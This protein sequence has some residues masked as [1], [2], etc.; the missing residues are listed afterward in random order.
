MKYTRAGNDFLYLGQHLFVYADDIFSNIMENL[1]RC[2]EKIDRLTLLP[3]IK[4]YIYYSKIFLRITRVIE[5][6]YLIRGNHPNIQQ[7]IQMIS[8]YLM[9]WN[10]SD[11]FM[12]NHLKYLGQKGGAKIAKSP[13]LRKYMLELNI[14]ESISDEKALEYE[15]IFGQSTPEYESV[16]ENL[17]Y[18]MKN[19]RE[20]FYSEF[21]SSI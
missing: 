14:P 3:E 13:N 7:I 16:D 18:L 2:L 6:H 15:D 9:K 21:Y 19:E 10:I 4:I 12:K 5:I 1:L 20:E 17:Q 11:A 8:H